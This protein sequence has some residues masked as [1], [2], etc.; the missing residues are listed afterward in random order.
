VIEAQDLLIGAFA[1]MLVIEGLLPFF[2]PRLWR[3]LFERATK[4]SDSQLR[5]IGLSSMLAGLATLYAF[6]Q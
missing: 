3:S 1:L 6:W 5:F 4:L 2:S